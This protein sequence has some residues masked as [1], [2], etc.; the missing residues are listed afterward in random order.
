MIQLIKKLLQKWACMHK[1][2]LYK[3]RVVEA[4]MGQ[5]YYRHTFVCKECGKFKQMKV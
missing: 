3:E 5:R 1:W 4:D 2:E